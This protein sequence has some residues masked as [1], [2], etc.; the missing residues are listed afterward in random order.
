[1]SSP[2]RRLL[3]RLQ[4]L[5]SLGVDLGLDRM[6][7]AL[8][9]LGSPE[10]SVP[11]VQVA[12]T[13]GKGST[14]AMVEAILRAA[15]LRT[16]LFTSPHLCRFTER[17]RIDGKEI[18]GDH[19]AALDGPVAA[20]DV[21]LTYFETATALAFCAFAE[22]K[23]DVA[24]LETGLGGRLD[25][26]TV[27]P[28]IA[29]AITGIS[30]DHTDLLGPTLAHIA[31]EKA[32]IA[33]PG[34]VMLAGN[35][36]PEAEDVVVAET[37]RV[38]APLRWLDAD[39]ARPNVVLALAGQYQRNNAAIAA[40]LARIVC[41]QLG[42][43]LS[44]AAVQTGLGGVRWPGRLERLPGG[45]LLDC[46]HNLEG[47]AM[48]ATAL[49]D[50]P[51]PRVLVTSIVRGK[52]AAAILATLAPEV[53]HIITTRSKNARALPPEALAALTPNAVAMTNPLDALTQ[54][55]LRAGD[56]LVVVAGSIP[57]VGEIRAYL[58]GET[59]DPMPISDPLP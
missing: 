32:G 51:R 4:G 54:A 35:L 20:T 10:Q 1:M 49:R 36:P 9:L 56:G 39:F 16:G 44:D 15:G 21:P 58:M 33:R 50:E 41:L 12:G 23:V 17:I 40:E 42:R 34:V 57:L 26:T 6:R 29:T 38:G 28:A 43:P 18:D 3:A 13:N 27:A 45:I 59:A 30:I 2:Y 52:D 5:N 37:A 7:R 46:A 11:A 25:A 8:T 55:R 53:D 14:V 47:A 24:V 19:L 22:A 31:R 48:L